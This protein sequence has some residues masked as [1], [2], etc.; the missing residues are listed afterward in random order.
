MT[1]GPVPV[2]KKSLQLG[3]EGSQTLLWKL[4]LFSSQNNLFKISVVIHNI[5]H[6]AFWKK[7]QNLALSEIK[8]LVWVCLSC[9]VICSAR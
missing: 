6:R 9:Q 3:T 5:E 2:C 1:T 8:S 7:S 4:I